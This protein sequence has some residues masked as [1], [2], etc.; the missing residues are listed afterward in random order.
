MLDR[1]ISKELVVDSR[2]QIVLPLRSIHGI[3]P[4]APCRV[5]QRFGRRQ[6][7][8]K[9]AY[10]GAYVYDIGD[11]KVHDAS[12]MFRE[13][14][15][16]KHMDKD[17]ISP[18]RFNSW[19]DR[20]Y[21]EWLKK[22]IQNV[23][24]QTPCNFRSVMEKEAKVMAELQEVKKEAQE[25]YAKFVDNQNNLEKVTQEVERL[26]RAYD[27][28][29]TWVKEKIERMWYEILEDK[30]SLGEGFFLMLRYLFQQHKTQGDGDGAG[31]SGAT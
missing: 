28:F 19:Y 13:W 9:E 7:V 24:S 14:K 29:D 17:T 6:N 10:Y 18:D 8:P 3:R 23:S 4:Y 11:D 15:S 16:A 26:R 30:G 22:D 2:R 1:F 31:P 25:L 12:E 27:D 20:G 5:L 21:K